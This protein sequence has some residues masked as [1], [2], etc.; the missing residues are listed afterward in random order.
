MIS[1]GSWLKHV[2]EDLV[3][4]L[5]KLIEDDPG[6]SAPCLHQGAWPARAR[7]PTRT[8]NIC[9]RSIEYELA[10]HHWGI[11]SGSLALSLGNKQLASP[12]CQKRNIH[13]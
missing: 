13:I 8:L 10:C 4:I 12:R 6:L 5:V 2:L 3:Q 11:T 9:C 1:I 7:R